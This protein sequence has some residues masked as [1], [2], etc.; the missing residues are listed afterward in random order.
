MTDEIWNKKREMLEGQLRD[1]ALDLFAH[2]G[3]A[4][5]LKMLIPNTKPQVFIVVGDE[6]AIKSLTE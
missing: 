5:A 3:S 1:D 6:R 4:G 2:M